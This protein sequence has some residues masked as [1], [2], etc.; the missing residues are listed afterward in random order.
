[1]PPFRAASDKAVGKTN[2]D[3]LCEPEYPDLFLF[4]S[5]ALKSITSFVRRERIVEAGPH[6]DALLV[7][8]AHPRA[9]VRLEE[10]DSAEHADQGE[11]ST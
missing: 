8:D 11:S 10:G 6:P 3:L 2:D 5:G 7:E 1:L 4:Q 9:D